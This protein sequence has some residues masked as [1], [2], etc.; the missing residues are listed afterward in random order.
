MNG[1]LRKATADSMRVGGGHG[2][3]MKTDKNSAPELLGPL[4]GGSMA[5]QTSGPHGPGPPREARPFSSL[6]IKTGVC[7]T[8]RNICLQNG[9]NNHN[10]KGVSF[11][12]S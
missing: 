1:C 4:F 12:L 8:S 5:P 3:P 2:K 7:R 10:A 9:R 6:F 11:Q